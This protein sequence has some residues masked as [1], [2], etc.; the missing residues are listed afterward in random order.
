MQLETLRLEIAKAL[1]GESVYSQE[2]LTTAISTLRKKVADAQS[3]L[4]ELKRE[5]AEKKAISNSIMPAYK[6]FKTWAEEF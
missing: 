1:T 5:D 4:D 3:Q 2:D 6:Q